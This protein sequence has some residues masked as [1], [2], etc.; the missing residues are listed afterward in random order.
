M[1]EI[2]KSIDRRDFLK[3]TGGVAALT[4]LSSCG[5]KSGGKGSKSGAEQ[6][7]GGESKGME[8]RTSSTTGDRLSLLGYG[9]MRWPK[10]D[11]PAA[12]G[13]IID[14]EAVNEL[15]DYAMEHGVNYFDTAPTYMQGWSE[16]VMGVAL[17]RHP[18]DSYYITTKLSNFNATTWSREES[19]ALYERSFKNLQTDYIDYLLLHSVGTGDWER[20]KSR[21]IDN[22]ILDYL[23]EQRA[24][25]RI[26]NL[27]FSFH[28]DI[29]VFDYLLSRH[30]EY[31]WDFVQ[32]Q[33][34][35]IDWKHA[36]PS[37]NTNAE[38]LYSE[39]EKRDIGVIVMEPLLGGR[40]STLPS[41][42]SKRLLAERPDNSI[43]SWAFRYAGSFPK[44]L[45]VLSGMTYMEHLQDNIKTYSSF[46]PITP[47]EDQ[48]LMEVA[49]M[50]MNYPM[51]SCTACQ[52]CMSCP[53]GLDIPA[54]FSHYNKC[55]NEGNYPVTTQDENYAKERRAFLVGYDRSVPKLRQADHCIGCKECVVHCPQKIDIPSEMSRVNHYVESLKQGKF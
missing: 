51:V 48:M 1:S 26:R 8:Y 16:P 33:L 13:N 32:I 9:C 22:G 7:Q 46:E 49:E 21:Y 35:Y 23:L 11:V 40:L 39:L 31:K 53:Y 36:D 17:S 3:I 55:I 5:V 14:Q 20:F 4:A 29:T 10:L 42:L 34:N 6:T 28:G 44:V 24:Q 43:A 27:G 18:R 2:K 54:I 47:S 30:D 37:R 50:L 52:Y 45:T 19:I 38:Y 41:H 25:G 15:V 12:D